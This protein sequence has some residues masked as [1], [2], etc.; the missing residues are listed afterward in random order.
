VLVTQE[1]LGGSPGPTHAPVIVA[2]LD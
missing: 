1:P 2:K